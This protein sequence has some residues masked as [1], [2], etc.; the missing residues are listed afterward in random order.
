MAD[1]IPPCPPYTSIKEIFPDVFQVEGG[2]RFG[3]GMWI[4]RNMHVVRQGKELT[5]IN[6]VRLCPEREA[7]LLALGEV[8]H[9]LR[10]GEFH[11]ADDP[12]YVHRFKPTLWAPPGMKHRAPDLK[13]NEE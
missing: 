5:L 7:D 12:Y 13:T 8:K 9:L 2:F 11:G 10:I 6:S 1:F 4:T 3:P